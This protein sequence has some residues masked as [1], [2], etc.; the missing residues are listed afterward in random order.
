MQTRSLHR[1]FS[2]LAYHSATSRLRQLALYFL[3]KYQ[4]KQHGKKEFTMSLNKT[5]TRFNQS[6]LY[7]DYTL[8][9]QLPVEKNM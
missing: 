1:Y 9:N 6:R 3:Y 8:N 4:S 2:H 7:S 5:Q